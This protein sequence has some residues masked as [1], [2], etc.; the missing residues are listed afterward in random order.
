MAK[1]DAISEYLAGIGKKGGQV[2]GTK[3]GFASLSDAER[4]ALL[5]KA[6][7]G[8]RKAHAARAAAKKKAK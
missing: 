8:R 1:R 7:A 5:Q 6:A 4:K 2:T 3:K